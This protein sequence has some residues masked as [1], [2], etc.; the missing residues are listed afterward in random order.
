[1]NTYTVVLVPNHDVI[2]WLNTATEL[3]INNKLFLNIHI[4]R[5]N[6]RLEDTVL[7]YIQHK[8]AGWRQEAYIVVLVPNHDVI[9]LPNTATELFV[10][11]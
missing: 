1:M 8:L 7:N 3:L 5:L 2:S 10:N 4:R 6:E 9:R 11:K